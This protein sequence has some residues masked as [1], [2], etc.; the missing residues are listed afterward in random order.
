[1]GQ[2]E[3]QLCWGLPGRPW[4]LGL[5][6]SAPQPGVDGGVVRFCVGLVLSHMVK[7]QSGGLSLQE[8]GSAVSHSLHSH[9][10]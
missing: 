5:H 1:M 7:D 6:L 8:L 9:C 3:G 2:E 10:S 4:L